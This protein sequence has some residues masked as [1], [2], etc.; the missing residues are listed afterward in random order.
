MG[1]AMTTEDVLLGKSVQ[2]S[3]GG[4]GWSSILLEKSEHPNLGGKHSAR[5][6]SV[7][8][9]HPR[10]VGAEDGWSHL[11]AGQFQH[12]QECH[13]EP[14][15]YI[16]LS[17]GPRV[18]PASLVSKAQ[19]MRTCS[20]APSIAT[21]LPRRNPKSMLSWRARTLLADRP[22]GFDDPR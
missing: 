22:S 12:W 2:T 15:N 20:E 13:C 16:Q 4:E 3:G 8:I 11:A 18:I 1:L 19:L 10:F 5:I 9:F 17:Q 21:G 7:G 6:R 14:T